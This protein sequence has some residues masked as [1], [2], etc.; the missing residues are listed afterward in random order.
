MP[1]TTYRNRRA[2]SIENQVLRLTLLIEGGHVAEILHKPSGINPLWTPPWPSIEPSSYSL[3]RHPEY[4]CDAESKLLAGIMGHNLAMDIFGAPS[5]E[6]VVAG[7]TVHGEASVARWDITAGGGELTARALLPNAQLAIE[8]RL[9]L[10]ENTIW[11]RETVENVSAADRPIAWTQHVTLGPP[12]LE[13]G[14]TQFRAS[15]TRSKTLEADY[16]GNY[17]KPGAEFDWPNAP[18]KGGGTADLRVYTA[19]PVSAA[20]TTHLMDPRREHAFFA[21]FS[22]AFRLIFGYAWRQADFPWLGIWEENHS[23]KTPPWNGETMTRGMEFGASPFPEPRR[24]M[25]ARNGLFGV[26]GYRWIPAQTRVSVDYCALIHEADRVPEDLP[27][28]RASLGN[29]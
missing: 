12:F 23:R 11:F 24:K 15:A 19:A 26:P 6:E 20:F 10:G 21:A 27:Y 22:P 9:I 13:R 29:P 8:R 4:G 16:D 7:L 2:V 5:P 18:L 28:V 14:R 3:A 17:V 25:I 1:E